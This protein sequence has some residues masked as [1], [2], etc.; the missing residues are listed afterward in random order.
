MVISLTVLAVVIIGYLLV[1]GL[2]RNIQVGAGTPRTPPVDVVA[3]ASAQARTAPFALVVPSAVPG[4]WRGRQAA[5]RAGN[6]WHLEFVTPENRFAAVDQAAGPAVPVLDQ[7]LPGRR[8][9]GAVQLRSGRWQQYTA[10]PT[11]GGAALSGLVQQRGTT[12]VVV[13]GTADAGVLRTLA[14]SLASVG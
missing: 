13:W 12:T 3:S 9:S 4:G 11:D 7:A 1:S 8:R 5:L 14:G 2:W 6:V 10:A